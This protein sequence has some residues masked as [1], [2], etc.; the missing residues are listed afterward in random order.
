MRIYRQTFESRPIATSPTTNRSSSR[1]ERKKR[2]VIGSAQVPWNFQQLRGFSEEM[3]RRGLVP[4][5]KVLSMERGAAD[6]E[7][8]QALRLDDDEIVFTLRRIRYVD[9]EP[10]ALVTS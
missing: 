7:T 4:S 1:S 5:A 6:P 10:V 2:P 8:V 9:N 3:R